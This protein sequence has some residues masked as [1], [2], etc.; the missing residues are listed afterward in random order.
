MEMIKFNTLTAII[1]ASLFFSYAVE[2][3]HEDWKRSESVDSRTGEINVFLRSP[4]SYD[5]VGGEE[6]YSFIRYNCRFNS[7]T[8]VNSF[9]ADYVQTSN[10][11]RGEVKGRLKRDWRFA[12]DISFTIIVTNPKILFA[13]NK[14]SPI[15]QISERD[16][17]EIE[18]EIPT[19]FSGPAKFEYDVEGFDE[20]QCDKSR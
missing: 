2:A 4:T 8:V 5:E 9:N 17:D 16:L 12:K 13:P 19:A 1:F 6:E 10:P 15:Q 14:N 18:I 11:Y 20:S 3:S 7:F